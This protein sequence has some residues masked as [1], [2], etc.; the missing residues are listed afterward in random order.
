MNRAWTGF[1]RRHPVWTGVAVALVLLVLLFDWN[2]FRHPLERY[3][4]QKTER[5]FRIS[6]LHVTLGWTLTPTIRMRDVYFGNAAWSKEKAMAQIETLEF[7]V[8][9]RDLPGKVLIPRVAL[10]HPELVFE[11]QPDDRKNWILSDPSDKSPSKLRIG[12]LSVDQG[13]LRYIDYGMP[14]SIDIQGS[15]FDPATQAQVK[16]A[17]AKPINDRYTTQYDFKGKYHD[18]AFSGTALTGE[19]LSFQESGVPF[20]LKGSLVAGTTRVDV[21]GTIADADNISAIDTQ[22]RIRGRTL[23]NLYPFLLLPLPASPPYELQGHLILKGKTYTMDD[24][25]G[26]IGA[27]D[28]TGHGTYVDKTPRPLLTADLHSKLLKLADL[29]PLIGVQTRESGG[30]PVASQA[31]TRNRPAAKATEQATDPDHLLPAGSFDGSRLQKIDADVSLDAARLEMPNA[32]PLESIHASLHLHD[33]ILKLTPLDFGF[34]GGTIASQ[35]LL[36][37]REPTLKSELQANFRGI[38]VDRLVPDKEA[39]AQG[40]GTVGATIEL[41]GTGN[42][43]ADAAAK[44]NGRIAAAIAGGRISNLLD[45]ASSLN[46]GKVLELLVGGD[47][48]IEVNCGGMAFDIKDGQ[49]TSSLFLID[50]EQTQILGS[51]TFD[52]ARER[53]DFTIAPKPKRVGILSL[54]TPVRLYGSFRKPDFQIEKGPLLAR[55]GGALALAAAAPFAALLPLIET[56]PGVNTN[57]AAVERQVGGAQKQARAA[58]KKKK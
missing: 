11:R 48:T 19:V 7:S 18:A 32:L 46:G 2:W 41:K 54:R 49:G 26:R 52:L 15:T 8:S 4:S 57:C 17:K 25:A 1:P 3:I 45:A 43:I 23:A 24:L 50:T 44:S 12:T 29:G 13:R 30:K 14:F 20:P 31:Q 9:L 40:A 39:I 21:E 37:A 35:V 6:D 38:R 33:S 56:G 55:A 53:F 22:L 47:K 28:V 10:T 5:T 34:A 42:S 27:T 16:D 58:A 36:D 51:G